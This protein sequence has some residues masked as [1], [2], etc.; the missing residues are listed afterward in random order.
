MLYQLSYGIIRANPELSVLVV[1][2]Y[3]KFLFCQNKTI[4]LY[5][6]LIIVNLKTR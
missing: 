5:G 3:R 1:Q 4:F 6:I 2:M